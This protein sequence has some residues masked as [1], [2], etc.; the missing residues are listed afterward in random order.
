MKGVDFSDFWPKTSKKNVVE[1]WQ[2]VVWCFWACV[3]WL[4]GVFCVFLLFLLF[5]VVV[6]LLIVFLLD[7]HSV[8]GLFGKGVRLTASSH[9]FGGFR[10]TKMHLRWF[11]RLN[12]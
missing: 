12:K 2:D 7:I 6:V 10:G 5:G 1:N 4:L 9:M 8:D 3:W 11:E